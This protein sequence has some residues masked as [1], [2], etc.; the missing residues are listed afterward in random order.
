MI[1]LITGSGLTAFGQET[2]P[3]NEDSPESVIKDLY[4]L[5][6]IEKG[7]IHDWDLVRE[8]FHENANIV[9]RTSMT[10]STVFDLDGFIGDFVKF[11]TDYN[12]IETGFTEKIVKMKPF[13][14]G[15]IASVLVVYEASV[16]G[17]GRQPQQ[18][19]D[20]I[21]LIRQDVGWKIISIIN[22]IPIPERPFPDELRD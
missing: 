5:V 12:I 3:E 17:S 22:E 18:G 8:L 9:L 4:Q 16:P 15:D 14:F 19:L 10:A 7:K 1:I 20:S 21:Q 2:V 11:V 13:I 6:S